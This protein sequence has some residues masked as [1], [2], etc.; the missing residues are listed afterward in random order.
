MGVRLTRDARALLHA[1]R[2]VHGER[3]GAHTLTTGAR[4]PFPEGQDASAYGRRV[5]ATTTP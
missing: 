5:N 4:L 3:H 1:A 2:R